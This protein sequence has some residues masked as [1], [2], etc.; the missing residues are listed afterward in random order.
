[1]PKEPKTFTVADPATFDGDPFE[2]ADRA[3]KQA[4]AVA[5]VLRDALAGSRNMMRSAEME[6]QIYAD[7]KADA[8]AFDESAQA[9]ILAG[10][11]E[12]AEQIDRGCK[13]LAKAASFNP[14]H[15]PK[16]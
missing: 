14:R 7:G 3:L 1:M 13:L 5:V 15:P 12:S 16:E 6:R 9:R 2:V 8:E 4:G 11:M 10:L